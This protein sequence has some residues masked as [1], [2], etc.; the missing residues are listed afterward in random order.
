MFTVGD[1][2]EELAR[3]DDLGGEGFATAVFLALELQRPLFL[4][5]RSLA[6]LESLVEAV[7]S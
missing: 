7:A 2:R 5:S 1:V 4:E 3:N 6:S